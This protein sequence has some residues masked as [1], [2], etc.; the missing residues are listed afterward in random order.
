MIWVHEFGTALEELNA[1]EMFWWENIEKGFSTR[2]RIIITKTS[3][4]VAKDKKC[5]FE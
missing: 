4:L 2:R 5:T 3:G 1:K